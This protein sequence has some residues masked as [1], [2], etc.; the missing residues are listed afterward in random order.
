MTGVIATLPKFQFSNALGLPM[1]GGTL[2][3]YL[4]GTTTP[5]TTYQDQALATANTNPISLDSRGECT[6]WLDS[7][8]TYKFV[9]K[10]EAGVTQW[11]VD[12]IINAQALVDQLRTDLAAPSG[13]SLVGYLPAGTDAVATTVEN[14]LNAAI[15]FNSDY[16]P[17]ADGTTD[18]VVKLQAAINKAFT[19]GG[20]VVHLDGDYA[21][22]E[23]LIMLPNVKLKGSG[24]SK[25]ILR[26]TAAFKAAMED[27]GGTGYN[28]VATYQ[29]NT[30]VASAFASCYDVGISNISFIFDTG[31]ST[32][33]S[34][35][36]N[37]C[38]GLNN[39]KRIAIEDCIFYGWGQHSVDIS[40]CQ[41]VTV[42]RTVSYNGYWSSIQVDQGGGVY[43]AT[44]GATQKSDH[45]YVVNNRV[46]GTQSEY[47]AIQ[48]HKDG[49]NDIYITN[50]TLINNKASICTDDYYAQS[51]AIGASARLFIK[52]NYV[53]STVA[54]SVGIRVAKGATHTVISGNKVVV[55]GE[56][57]MLRGARTSGVTAW[58]TDVFVRDNYFEGSTSRLTGCRK[59][60][61][62]D[63][64]FV[65]A[66][67]TVRV[68]L[69]HGIVK[70]NTFQGYGV[71]LEAVTET[72]A[73]DAS[74]NVYENA[75]LDFD[76]NSMYGPAG[77]VTVS[78]KIVCTGFAQIRV[79]AK[80]YF[81]YS[82]AFDYAAGGNTAL[83][84]EDQ[85]RGVLRGTVVSTN[86]LDG[87]YWYNNTKNRLE[88]YDGS[89]ARDAVGAMTASTTYDPPSLAVGTSGAEQTT[90]VTGAA[91][92]DHVTAAFSINTMGL[93]IVARVSAADSVKWYFHN[94]AG[95]PNGT[96]D[97]ASGVASF[98]VVK[99]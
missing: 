83:V 23:P 48:I 28:L 88:I 79:R 60:Q 63:N 87:M 97:L 86:L 15:Y 25:T 92:G 77:G 22:G 69:D 30:I 4:A 93:Q 99:I 66:S 45:I 72:D 32:G 59:A 96:Q 13:A 85:F 10:N 73:R 39:S 46:E 91:L 47:G 34:T 95:N 18:D 7:T 8:K 74:S 21:L 50:N 53:L 12:N 68:A 94:P 2:T 65:S 84:I 37:N 52:D 90:T 40:G 6:L 24:A 42:Q 51:F 9:L 81:A 35:H 11:T 98:R 62:H 82:T 57:L 20:G 61:I 3:S 38:I 64:R 78:Y 33:V 55:V 36:K 41:D 70:N 17:A 16:T 89:L 1:S 31:A 29:Y 54:A 80:D 71:W 76:G 75:F 19:L 14:R 56:A 43:G 27:A 44:G 67:A 58:N 49:G 26:P 5:A